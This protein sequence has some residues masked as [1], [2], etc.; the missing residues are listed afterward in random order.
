MLFRSVSQSRYTGTYDNNGFYFPFSDGTSTTTLGYDSSG[1]GN[2]WTLNNVSLTAGT[3]YDWM[4]D[5]PSNNFAVLS[6]LA[7][8]GSI[9]N[10]N[11]QATNP[12]SSGSY[13][14]YSTVP[15]VSG[16]YYWELT[17]VDDGTN[18][19]WGGFGIADP[20]LALPAVGTSASNQVGGYSRGWHQT[21]RGAVSSYSTGLTNNGASINTTLRATTAGTRTFMV[22]YDADSGKCWMGYEGSWWVGDPS[23][24]T[25]EYFTATAPMMPVVTPYN[26]GSVGGFALVT[27][28]RGEA[29]PP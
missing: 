17:V 7:A 10:A 8:R 19:R 20:S 3:T 25:G 24:G 21:C 16:K 14:T 4:T 26:D 29:L 6:P 2:N 1:N 18:A 23:A 15:M 28:K 11:L 22:A 9:S 12:G 27:L 13:T 5:T